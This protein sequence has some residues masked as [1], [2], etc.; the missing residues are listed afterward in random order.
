MKI[1][2]KI[3]VT[4]FR[5]MENCLINV[6]RPITAIIGK[7]ATLKTTLLGMIAHPFSL[8]SGA[9]AAERPLTGGKKFNSLMSD[10]FKF[11]PDYDKPGE[12]EWTLVINKQIY[13]KGTFTIHSEK[14]SK[15]TQIRFWSTEG[16]EKGMGYIQLPVIYLSMKRLIPVGEE[17]KLKV[18]HANL[19]DEEKDFYVKEHNNILISNETIKDVSILD[20][21]N[22][23][24]IGPSTQN[25]DAQTISSGQDNVGKIILAALSMI[26][27]KDKYPN[28]YKGGIICIDEIESTLYPAAQ[29]KMLDFLFR[30]AEK[31]MIQFFFTTHSMSVIKYLKTCSYT[32]RAMI[33]YLRKLG[34]KIRVDQNP[35][36]RDIENDLNV[37]AGKRKNETKI[38]VYCEDNVGVWI[39][40]SLL[41]KKIKD[42][43]IFIT[44]MNLSWSVYKT[45]YDHKVPEF[46]NNII[47]LDGDVKG[48]AKGWKNYPKINTNVKFL[49][50]NMAPERMLYETLY[51]LD[52]TDSFWDNGFSGYSR[53][54]CFKYCINHIPNEDNTI[55]KIKQWFEEQKSYA[56]RGYCRFINL[57]KNKNEEKVE[58]FIRDFISAYNIIAK[59]IGTELIIYD[60]LKA[61]KKR[62]NVSAK[63]E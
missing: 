19:S 13:E 63:G 30:V 32:S 9:M 2:E 24:T 36:L 38:K 42:K 54:V 56:G 23:H 25:T 28:D 61:P 3:N 45:L 48:T 6:N 39:C 60:A 15:S 37:E 62:Q 16:H 52:E 40:K 49:P 33:V 10:K 8:E 34:G 31:Y 5:A 20:S 50:T 27:L 43:V 53:S 4:K 51:D 55:D 26:R 21:N 59:R 18:E 14:R 12:H 47:I 35:D 7:N 17:A 44:N 22:K 11:S 58:E 41:P 1:I 29:E 46:R 57:W